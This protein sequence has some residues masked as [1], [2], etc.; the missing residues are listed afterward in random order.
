MHIDYKLI[1]SRRRSIGII[2]RPNKE[3]EVRAPYGVSLRAVEKYISKKK[4]WIKKNIERH[5]EIIQL[6]A[7]KKYINGEKYL[8]LGRELTLRIKNALFPSVNQIDTILEV[9]TDGKKGI[10]KMLIGRWYIKKA[11][12]IFSARLKEILIKYKEHDFSPS[13]L[14]VRSLRSR[15]GSCTSKGKIT[16]NTELVKLD[17]RFIEYV[18]I[19]ELCHLKYHNHGKDFYRLLEKLSPD[20]KTIRKEMRKY[21]IS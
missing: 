6:N 20:Y 18:I 7:G 12:E 4:D 3:V 8:F 16:I 2:I 11:E 15:W 1:F 17:E 21:S 14:V 9:T 19:H 10:V 13:Q 5:S